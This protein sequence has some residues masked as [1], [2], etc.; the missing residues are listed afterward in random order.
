M[1]CL[2]LSILGDI[3]TFENGN[4]FITRKK[5]TKRKYGESFINEGLNYS[6]N[7]Y[8]FFLFLGGIN[9]DLIDKKYSFNTMLIYGTLKGMI[10]SKEEDYTE[11]CKEEYSRIYKKSKES[12]IKNLI[13]IEYLNTFSDL[14]SKK[15]YDLSANDSN[16]L[17][18]IIPIA[19]LYWKKDER[20]KLISEMINNIIL[21]KRKLNIILYV[22]IS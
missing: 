9:R 2:I 10:S 6:Q 22:K 3:L 1:E 7:K 13:P 19:L 18:R 16:V 8:F 5:I 14:E 12:S 11:K 17:P 15:K 21:L 20:K 4:A